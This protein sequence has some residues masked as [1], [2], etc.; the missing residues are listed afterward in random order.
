MNLYIKN[1]KNGYETKAF[2]HPCSVCTPDNLK[3]SFNQKKTSVADLLIPIP[4]V[5]AS[6]AG[7]L[8]IS[9]MPYQCKS[10]PAE[11]PFKPR[12]RIGKK[13]SK[14]NG[15]H[16]WIYRKHGPEGMGQ[17]AEK[18][19]TVRLI[20]DYRSTVSNGVV[21]SSPKRQKDNGNTQ[22]MPLK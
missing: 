18:N 2:R 3:K 22:L 7:F 21:I 6:G 14:Q 10:L 8:R 19:I 13:T 16:Q 12:E 15:W 4:T 17:N 20:A 9:S 5:T 1:L 11:P